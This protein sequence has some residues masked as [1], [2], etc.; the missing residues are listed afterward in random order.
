M[1]I[2]KVMIEFTDF[3]PASLFLTLENI[4]TLTRFLTFPDGIKR[5]RFQMVQRGNVRLK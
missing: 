4:G 5:E 1:R 2:I 3:S